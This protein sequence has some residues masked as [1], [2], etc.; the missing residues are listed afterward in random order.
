M[1]LTCKYCKKEF[2]GRKHR[3]YCSGSCR[4]KDIYK[5]NPNFFSWDKNGNRNPNWKGDEMIKVCPECGG[6]FR[7]H[8]KT[9]K[10]C[11]KNCWRISKS[12]FMRDGEAARL[13]QFITNP[14][15]PQVE[16]FSMIKSIYPDSVINYPTPSNFSIDIALVKEKIAIEY[17][18]SYW[19]DE[20]KD[21]I[22]QDKL[23]KEGWLFI[24]YID[25][26]PTLDELNGSIKKLLG[27]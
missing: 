15:R 11:D 23:E 17:D 2:N 22:R 20:K 1:K 27:Y 24:R 13:N 26:I 9:Q 7:A 5:P 25:N 10:F 6:T 3:I 18:G 16:L 8:R 4:S 12:K 14:S 19:H 21:R